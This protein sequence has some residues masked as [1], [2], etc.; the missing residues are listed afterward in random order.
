MKNGL[1]T[2]PRVS[3]L[4]TVYNAAPYLREAIESILGQNFQDWEAII[5]ENGSSDSSPLIIG[6]Y[7]D[8]RLKVFPMGKNVGRI[9][10]L[11]FAF[12]QV[13]GEYIAVLDADD[14]ASPDRFAKQVELLDLRPEVALVGS[15]AQF[16]DGNSKVFG[17]FRPPV[18]DQDLNNCL[19]WMNPIVH[20]SA[21]YRSDL[22][23]LVGGYPAD[24]A[25]GHDFALTLALAQKARI[26]MIDEFLCRLRV[27]TTSMTRSRDTQL[28]VARETLLLF[29]RAGM[30][31]S[32]DNN[33]IRLNRHTIARATIGL[34]IAKAKHDSL[35]DGLAMIIEAV[36]TSPAVLW[37]NGPVRRFFASLFKSRNP[38]ASDKPV[39]F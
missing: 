2:V 10:A 18:A 19:G 22:A 9:A 12:D 21:M 25:W 23:K 26:A 33:G 34:G 24:F 36:A 14:V 27:L 31:I 16:V 17:E 38:V 30:Q 11:R 5:V 13:K 8:S 29:Q 37:E 1:D 4:M 7:A 35:I 15:W 39:R 3:V 28:L 6:D 32:M 20:S